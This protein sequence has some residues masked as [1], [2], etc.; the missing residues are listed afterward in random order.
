MI[1]KSI[2]CILLVVFLGMSIFLY[3]QV[4]SLPPAGSTGELDKTEIMRLT[5]QV[6]HKSGPSTA[7]Q[8]S[9]QPPPKATGA[10]VITRKDITSPNY[11]VAERV[12]Q[13]ERQSLGQPQPSSPAPQQ[14]APLPEPTPTAQAP[15]ITLA[16]EIQPPH[17]RNNALKE[18]SVQ[19][20]GQDLQLLVSTEK[21]LERFTYFVATTPGRV[22]VDLYGKFEKA[23]AVGKTPSNLLVKDIRTGLHN[24]RMRIVADLE[25]NVAATALVTQ[26]SPT[27][28]TIEIKRK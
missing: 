25:P 20:V 26:K 6:F 2:L 8:T 16:Q 27:E 18:L 4:A 14:P 17:A 23:K 1:K 21:Q 22:V 12:L 24:D 13:L 19:L 9:P 5:P 10:D 11:K 3:R 28:L 15:A 7:P